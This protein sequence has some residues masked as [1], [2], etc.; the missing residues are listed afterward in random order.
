MFDKG[1]SKVK[2]IGVGIPD[3]QMTTNPDEKPAEHGE[4]TPTMP[5]PN[6]AWSQ[7]HRN[8]DWMDS[9]APFVD[10]NHNDL[11]L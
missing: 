9:Y 1:Q 11:V 4:T 8:Y 6:W 5:S 3:N 10:V 2:K 7:S